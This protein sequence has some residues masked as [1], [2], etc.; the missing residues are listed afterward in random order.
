MEFL[1]Q[2]VRSCRRVQKIFQNISMKK[3]GVKEMGLQR[4]ITKDGTTQLKEL[5][6]GK[7]GCQG[8]YCIIKGAAETS[9]A[10]LSC[11]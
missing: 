8:T 2:K 11:M 1:C 4:D 9:G 7:K 10:Y 6:G 3:M 5:E